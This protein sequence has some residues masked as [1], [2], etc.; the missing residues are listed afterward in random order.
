[1][2][3]ITDRGD[4]MKKVLTTLIAV[5]A[6]G[7]AAIATSSSADARWGYGYGWRG[8]WGWGPGPFV[9]GALI[10]G[11]LAAGPYY[12]GYGPR[13]YYGY[14]GAPGY[15]GPGYAPGCRR[16]WNGYAWVRGCY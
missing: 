11:A 9:A 4:A 3:N 12:Y 2:R 1:L 15:Y 7:A 5:A 14:Y 13:P 8:G 6:L 16:V 10:G